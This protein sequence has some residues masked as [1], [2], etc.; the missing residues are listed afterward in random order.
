MECSGGRKQDRIR[1]PEYLHSK[2]VF[3]NFMGRKFTNRKIWTN[4]TTEFCVCQIACFEKESW[5]GYLYNKMS[6]FIQAK[7][8]IQYLI[9]VYLIVLNWDKLLLIPFIALNSQ[10]WLTL[11][12]HR[13]QTTRLL[14]PW[15]L[16]GKNIEVS[17]H[18]LLQILFITGI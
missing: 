6:A 11:W 15:D 1:S 17:C 13:L 3:F 18:F 8:F 2:Y 7:S 9:L 12:P 16:L 4:I 14:C 10:L 5:H